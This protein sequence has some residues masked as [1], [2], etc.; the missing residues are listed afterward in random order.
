MASQKQERVKT[1]KPKSQIPHF[2]TIEEEAEFWDTHNLTEFE[3]ELED[4]TG[5]VQFVERRA[6]ASK[7]I[8]VRLDERAMATLNKKAKEQ[9][10]GP[11]TLVRMWIQE[12]LRR[13]NI[14]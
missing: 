1:R 2:K 6:P 5:Q 3:N 12:H 8:T 11:S 13:E 14:S 9:G 10:I 7:A 4:M